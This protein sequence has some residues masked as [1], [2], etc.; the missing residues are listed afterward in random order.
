MVRLKIKNIST[1]SDCF[2]PRH[3]ESNVNAVK[4]TA[5]FNAE[6]HKHAISLLALKLGYSLKRCVQIVK[7]TSL[8]N[9]L[10]DAY[11]ETKEFS[12][13][14]DSDWAAEI[15][16]HAVKTLYDNKMNKQTQIPLTQDIVLLHEYLKKEI[17]RC[18]DVMKNSSIQASVWTL[19][20]HAILARLITFNRRRAGEMGRLLL[21]MIESVL[22]MKLIA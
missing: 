22:S 19:A 20:A 10:N 9:G 13:L 14:L 2:K 1:L 15:S 17:V 5:G 11:Q 4:E 6:T 18:L 7:S 3:F 12:E 21:A 16:S 8:R